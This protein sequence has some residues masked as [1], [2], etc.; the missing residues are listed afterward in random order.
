MKFNHKESPLKIGYLSRVDKLCR[1]GLERTSFHFVS[2]LSFH[3]WY[4]LSTFLPFF[5][6]FPSFLEK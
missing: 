6:F 3:P 4:S 1:I 5:L 2:F